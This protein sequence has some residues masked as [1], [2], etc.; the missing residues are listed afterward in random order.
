M[1]SRTLLRLNAL[2]EYNQVSEHVSSQPCSNSN[3][4]KERLI[5]EIRYLVDKYPEG[6]EGFDEDSQQL[7]DEDFIGDLSIEEVEKDFRERK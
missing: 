3:T 4:N 2:P 7:F 6:Y 1:Q 5:D